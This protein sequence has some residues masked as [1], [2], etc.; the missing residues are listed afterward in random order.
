MPSR[1]VVR[2]FDTD[3]LYHVYNRGVNK[4][5]IFKD[6]RDYSVFLSFLKYALLSDEHIN[7]KT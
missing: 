5:L 6:E 3:S 4:D 7:K 2:E 1:N